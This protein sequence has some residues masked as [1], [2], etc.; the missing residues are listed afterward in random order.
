MGFLAN[1][2]ARAG[3]LLDFVRE[4]LAFRAVPPLL[5]EVVL[6]LVERLDDRGLLATSDEDLVVELDLELSLVR[7]ARHVLQSLEP[8]GICAQY[9]IEAMLLQAANDPD[10]QFIER[11][12]R[13]HLDE[14]SRNK[15]PDVARS[16]QLSVDELQDLMQRMRSL[17]PRPAAAFEHEDN[18]SV[19][20]DAFVWLQ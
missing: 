1:V 3:S 11:L 4:Q 16:L 17:N 19:Q 15:L 10:I 9:A 12:L 20:P 8:L 18:L 14:L 2:P 7:E 6:L 5:A 13:V